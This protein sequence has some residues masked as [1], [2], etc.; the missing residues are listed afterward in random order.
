MHYFKLQKLEI[1]QLIND[2][3][4]NILL[5]WNFASIENIQKWCNLMVD[6]SKFNKKILIKVVVLS[7]NQF[8]N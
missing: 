7:Y 6:L 8:C 5:L 3:A 1:K 4:I 2:M